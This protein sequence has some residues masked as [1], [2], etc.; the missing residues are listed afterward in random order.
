MPVPST[1][2]STPIFIRDFMYNLYVAYAVSL[3]K[4]KQRTE[5]ETKKIRVGL[6]E[7]A[8]TLIQATF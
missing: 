5:A 4:K 7:R 8:Y 3:D 2:N 6:P 1:L